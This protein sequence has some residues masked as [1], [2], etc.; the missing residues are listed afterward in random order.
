MFECVKN[1]LDKRAIRK[2]VATYFD[3][4]NR[5]D[6]SGCRSLIDPTIGVDPIIF[7]QNMVRFRD[8]CRSMYLI[9]MRISLCDSAKFEQRPLAYVHVVWEDPDGKEW[10]EQQL[11]VKNCDKWF[12]RSTGRIWTGNYCSD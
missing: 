8:H 5:T 12:S 3:M 11:W 9:S 6:W 10:K 2:R 7:R 4:F 1:W